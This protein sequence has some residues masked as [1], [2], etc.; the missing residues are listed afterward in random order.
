MHKTAPVQ[1]QWYKLC[2]VES[3][4]FTGYWTFEAT[5]IQVG[6]L[7]LSGTLPF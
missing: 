7:K 3:G 4:A 1:D 6:Q 5:E 2:H